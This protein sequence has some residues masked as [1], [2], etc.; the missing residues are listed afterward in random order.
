MKIRFAAPE[1][2]PR[3]LTLLEQLS[4]PKP[5]E[6]EPDALTMAAAISERESN[7]V[8]LVAADVASGEVLGTA[9]VVLLRRL[10]RRGGL[11]ARLEDVVTDKAARGRGV[12]AALCRAAQAEAQRRGAYAID[13]RCVPKLARYYGK[14]GWQDAGVAMRSML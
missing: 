14:F 5:G 13:L 10:A 3:L 2:V 7:T 12:A 1:D 9:S 11:V 6:P 4:P 8:T